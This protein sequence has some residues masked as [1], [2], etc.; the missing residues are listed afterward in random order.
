MRQEDISYFIERNL[1][2]FSV[3]STGWNDL[4][5]RML[6]EMAVAGW[7][8][9]YDVFGKERSGELYC[10]IY[11]EN[12]ELNTVLRDIT[13][14]YA[15]LSQRICEI[16][17]DEGKKRT[18]GSLET[19]LCLNHF[20]EQKPAIDIDDDE[21]VIYDK[22]KVFNLKDVVKAEVEFD[23][24]NLTLYT[25]ESIDTDEVFGF[26][27]RESNYYLLLKTVPLHLFPEDMQELISD[28][29][30]NLRGCEICGY[31]ALYHNS[32]LRCDNE[33][34]EAYPYQIEDYED[35]ADYIKECQMDI[36]IDEEDEWKYFKDD[37]SFEKMPHHRILFTSTELEEY[38][39]L[40]F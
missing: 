3:N 2:N 21:N 7:N 32:C 20:L 9:E 10:P 33:S 26:S 36:F 30:Q 28:L 39:T 17:G 12:E 13:D 31:K 18:I 24:Q 5:G 16:C 6:Y 23:L 11:S 25:T 34:W 40:L 29:Y 35:K 27:Y 15:E 22:I 37:R 1:K 38:K 8:I 14:K 19:I 4:I